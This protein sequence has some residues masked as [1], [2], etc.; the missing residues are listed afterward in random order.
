MAGPRC[1]GR[2]GPKVQW[3]KIGWVKFRN[4]RSLRRPRP[5]QLRQ[6]TFRQNGGAGQ[7][8]VDRAY[9]SQRGVSRG[10]LD[11]GAA[12]AKRS[13]AISWADTATMPMSMLRKPFPWRWKTAHLPVG[14]P[15]ATFGSG[16]ARYALLGNPST[17][18]KML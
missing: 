2:G 5:E 8:G 11:A 18:E 1:V 14:S 16:K 9:S 4:A 6:Q 17:P 12:K 15:H 7:S 13:S 10:V 3:P